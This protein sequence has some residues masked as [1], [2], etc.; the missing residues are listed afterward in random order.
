MAVWEGER[1]EIIV[2]TRCTT[3]AMT[4]TT[5]TRCRRGWSNIHIFAFERKEISRQPLRVLNLL[6]E[7]ELVRIAAV[8]HG[9]NFGQGTARG[10]AA[11][12]YR[13]RAKEKYFWHLSDYPCFLSF[14]GV[15]AMIET[16]P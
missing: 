2:G 8:V 12:E 3:W 9:P 10:C 15:W 6:L 16:L 1:G 14:G 13:S 5:S 4:K 7:V 11:G